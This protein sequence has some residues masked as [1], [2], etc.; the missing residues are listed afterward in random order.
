MSQIKSFNIYCENTKT[1][2][3][4]PFG[5]TLKEII[6]E[7]KIDTGYPILGAMVNNSLKELDY[8]IYKPKTVYFI[9]YRHNDGKRMYLRSLSMVLF[10]A[11]VDLY[12]NEKLKIEHSVSNGLYCEFADGFPKDSQEEVVIKLRNRMKEIIEMTC[13]NNPE[14]AEACCTS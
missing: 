14:G 3:S 13:A 7:Q 1:E 2:K 6:T 12:P 11:V 4:Y 5:T 9:D 8:M 10:K